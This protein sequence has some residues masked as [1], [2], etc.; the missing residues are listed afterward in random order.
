MA[1]KGGLG[2]GLDALFDDNSNDLQIKQTLRIS[3]IEPNKNQPRRNFDEE[4]LGR[5]ADS[6]KEHGLLQPIV[7]RPINDGDYQIVA[8][9]RRWR[10]CRMLGMTEVPVIIKK[11]DDFETA[12]IALIE[13]LQREDLNPIEEAQGYQEL[14]DKYGMTQEAVSKTLGRSR[15]SIANLLRLLNL[16][17]EVKQMVE[18]KELS[19]GH[20]KALMA[21]P[22]NLMLETAKKAANG[23]VT[24]RAIEKLAVQKQNVQI[25]KEKPQKK[26]DNYYKE[27]EIVLNEELGRKVKVDFS[28]KKGIISIDFYDKNDLLSIAEALT[29]QKIPK[30]YIY[31]R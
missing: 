6:I 5:L 31:N 8:G 7:V 17:D 14:M 20:A 15:S 1:K 24:V 19:Q 3:E 23:S 10:A 27:M 12:Q 18:K 22:K 16:P 28:G 11:L 26:E 13:N 9:E 25:E 2:M 30:D 29:G 21:L 4:S